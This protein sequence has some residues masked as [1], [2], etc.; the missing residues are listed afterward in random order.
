VSAR[1][2]GRLRCDPLAGYRNTSCSG[3]R[4]LAAS[5]ISVIPSSIGRPAGPL[6]W[7][8]QT[9]QGNATKLALFGS[10]R[11]KFEHTT[12]PL[13]C[14]WRLTTSEARR[15]G[16]KRGF[17]PLRRSG[18]GFLLPSG[19]ESGEGGLIRQ[20]MP[21]GRRPC[22]R[23]AHRD[24]QQHSRAMESPHFGPRSAERAPN[25]RADIA[26][27][28]A[29]EKIEPERPVLGEGYAD[30]RGAILPTP[31]VLVDTPISSANGRIVWRFRPKKCG[32]SRTA[33]DNLGCRCPIGGAAHVLAC[34]ATTMT[35]WCCASPS[36]ITRRTSPS[37]LAG[38]ICQALEV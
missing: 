24:D 38:S 9:K 31:G 26:F 28:A 35:S 32:A 10:E 30:G 36:P 23:L 1:V 27:S 37:A 2:C 19:N 4:P 18:G 25:S 7:R 20:P 17:I 29:K 15:S 22:P 33:S 5:A 6:I 13:Q 21:S 16:I 34:A 11:R 3:S 12:Q 14:E 8:R